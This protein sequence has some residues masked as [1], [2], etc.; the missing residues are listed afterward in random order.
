ML[1]LVLLTKPRLLPERQSLLK[2][3]SM[4]LSM[5]QSLRERRNFSPN[6]PR[7]SK[8]PPLLLLPPPL[9]PPPALHPNLRLHLLHLQH[10]LLTPKLPPRRLPSLKRLLKTVSPRLSKPKR[11]LWKRRSSSSR[12]RL[13]NLRT[14]SRR[15]RGR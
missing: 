15:L 11:P 6:S 7:I 5:L 12:G 1:L 8:K 10:L 2:S 14:R 9:L 3:R 13:R 4:K